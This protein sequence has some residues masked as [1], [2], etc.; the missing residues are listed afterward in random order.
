MDTKSILMVVRWE[1]VVCMGKEV[2]GLR[3]TKR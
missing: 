1:G 2:R 3:N